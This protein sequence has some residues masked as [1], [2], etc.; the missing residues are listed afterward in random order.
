[1]LLLQKVVF[2]FA[3]LGVVSNAAADLVFT[4]PPRETPEQG[5]KIYGPV[6]AYLSQVTGQKVVYRHPGSWGIYQSSMQRDRYDLVFDGPHFVSWRLNRLRHGTLAKLPGKL[7]FVVVVKTKNRRYKKIAELRGRRVC[8]LAPP[9]LATLTLQSQFGPSRQPVLIMVTNFKQAYSDLLAGKCDAAVLRDSV[10]TRLGGQ[11]TGARVIFRSR[12]VPNQAFTAS[13]K[14]SPELRA[15][16][17]Q[18]LIATDSGT[19]MP[20]FL[21]RF[22]KG[23]ALI[24][25]RDAEYVGMFAF[26]KDIWGFGV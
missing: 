16:I 3:L 21:Q 11:Q 5:K 23:K 2:V 19:R 24:K 15:K 13:K 17:T 20:D 9:N 8:A 18:A 10:Y 7:G 4:A 12:P 1:M 6:A 14:V 26:L 25:A 22:A